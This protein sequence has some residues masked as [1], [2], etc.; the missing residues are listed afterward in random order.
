M[1][2]PLQKPSKVDRLYRK[3]A[4]RMDRKRARVAREREA[5]AE[6]RVLSMRVEARDGGLCR[7]CGCEAPRK[8]GDPRFWGQ[9]HHIVYRSAGGP[10]ELWNLVWICNMDSEREHHHTL[11][12]TGTAD[13]LRIWR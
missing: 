6:W 1:P 2:E 10:D 8:K 12:I 5:E 9:A 3:Y 4:S 11:R 13:D 7:V